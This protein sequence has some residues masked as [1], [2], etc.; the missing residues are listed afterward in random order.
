[1][2]FSVTFLINKFCKIGPKNLWA[3][4]F[5]LAIAICWF[6]WL[7]SWTFFS[8]KFLNPVA[9]SYSVRSLKNFCMTIS[10][11]RSF[12]NAISFNVESKI[13]SSC[14]PNS[15][16]SYCPILSNFKLFL[17]IS[18]FKRDNWVRRSC[19]SFPSFSLD[20]SRASI[21][22]FNPL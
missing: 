14:K 2:S 16:F 20:L 7:F 19:S 10:F 12:S 11:S 3:E 18:F 17:F 21:I 8:N 13:F 9:F 4:R 5:A 1:M 15:I 6:R 22:L